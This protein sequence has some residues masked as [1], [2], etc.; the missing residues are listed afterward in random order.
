MG[1]R[2]DFS[3]AAIFLAVAAAGCGRAPAPTTAPANIDSPRV[4][5]LVPA[6]TDLLLGMGAGEHLVA[7]SS[8]DADPRAASL[9]RVGDYL[10]T[11]WEQIS[12]LRP[13][14]VITQYGD[15]KTPQGFRDRAAALGIRQ[16][17]L[18]IERLD[19]VFAAL[20]TLGDACGEREKA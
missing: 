10:S 9:P 6:A 3:R 7:V 16:V 19:D 2:P 13:E 15:G 14:I 1:Q 8:Y 4:A 12:Q 20:D 11:D 5:S 17:N 18:R